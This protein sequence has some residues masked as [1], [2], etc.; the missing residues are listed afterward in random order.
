MGFF[1]NFMF[2]GFAISIFIYLIYNLTRKITLVYVFAVLPILF[3]NGY[4]SYYL[5]IQDPEHTEYN[6]PVITILDNEAIIY[7]VRNDNVIK[8]GRIKD[9]S[10]VAECKTIGCNY[11]KVSETKIN[12]PEW[13]KNN[14]SKFS[15]IDI[16]E[17]Y[18]NSN[19]I[20]VF[21]IINITDNFE[22]K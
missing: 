1:I 13:L 14:Y 7:E 3:F 10:L 21:N 8:I 4:S 2:A 18:N 20:T 12:Q 17:S 11:I 6:Y 19:I 9:S 22:T 15:L 5:M 16:V